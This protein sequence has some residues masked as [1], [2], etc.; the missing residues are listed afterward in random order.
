MNNN[1]LPIG[2]V[3]RI[4]NVQ[5][6]ISGYEATYKGKLFDYV[7]FV[8][9]LGIYKKDCEIFFNSENIT[10]VLF[11]GFKYDYFE[12]FSSSLTDNK[13]KIMKERGK[14]DEQ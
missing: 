14:Q 2:S 6:L 1:W 9:P 3:V 7:G 4:K 5:I 10:E 8:Y 13:E 12:Q 11:N